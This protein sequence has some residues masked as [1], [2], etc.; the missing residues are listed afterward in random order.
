MKPLVF[1]LIPHTHWDREWYGT[2]AAFL[3]RLI[4]M[5]DGARATLLAT[6]GLPFLLDGQTV[7]LGDYLAARP[8]AGPD[9]AGL[10]AGGQLQTGP[11]R[12]LV[13]E[14]IPSAESL[15]RN[16]LQGQ[17]D[18]RA[19]GGTS[20]TLYS[21]DA[22]GHPSVLP[23]LAREFGLGG[24]ALWRGRLGPDDF[25]R[26]EAPDGS[27]L[28]VY[29]FPAAGY[30]VGQAL[31]SDTGQ[32]RKA[33]PSLRNELLARA[34]TRHV[35]VFIGADHHPLRTDLPSL[36]AAMAELE[37]ESEVRLSS[38]DQ[39]MAA[40]TAE[41]K[42]ADV[43]R[44]ELRRG[45][46]H[47]W[48]LQGVHATRLPL[49]RQGALTE[50]LL[51]R[52]AEPLA[53]L[54]GRAGHGD[55]RPL[56]DMAWRLV[57]ET[58][59][60]DTICGT[61]HDDA[62]AEAS[63]RLRDAAELGRSVREHAMKLL[64]GVP[65]V[66]L[67]VAPGSG[68]LL[69]WNPRATQAGGVAVVEVTSFREDVLVGPP[70]GRRARRVAARSPRITLDDGVELQAQV[71]GTWSR[72]ERVDSALR[73]PDADRVDVTRLALLV[74]PMPGLGFATA[75]GGSAVRRPGQARS[76]VRADGRVLRNQHLRV[77]L[78]D[79]GT[80]DLEARNGVT[81]RRVLE[82]EQQA[83]LGDCYT[84]SPRGAIRTVPG[85]AAWHVIADGPLLAAVEGHSA[86]DTLAYRLRLELRYNET[87]LRIR[88]DVDNHAGDQRLRLRV[89]V[90]AAP[91]ALAG[92]AFGHERRRS[93]EPSGTEREQSVATAPAQRFVAAASA[94]G[95]AALLTPGHMEYE[96]R[97]DGQLLFTLLR[98]T[99]ELSRA[100]LPERP[101]HAAWPTPVPGAQCLGWSSAHLA[102]LP[103]RPAAADDPVAV[104]A[105]WEA[106]FLGPHAR[107]YRGRSASAPAVGAELIGHGLVASAVKSAEQGP[108]LVLRAVNLLDQEV[109]G[110]WRLTPAPAEAWQLRADESRLGPLPVE[111]WAIP[112]RIG[113]R[114]TSTILVL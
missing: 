72:V 38:L 11:S 102:L 40:A 47:T 104:V 12:V 36:A 66:P 65:D 62:A 15:V 3:A 8:D 25:F 94:H 113:P 45:H 96:L 23:M 41:L 26:W 46:Q 93:A 56:L 100:D 67:S 103:C 60:H 13:D 32:L 4:P 70:D 42:D 58:Q 5:L 55:Q 88:L 83:D 17:R 91:Y 53:A 105:A 98:S 30:E 101:G 108:G 84:A 14:L 9:V 59:F 92:A 50:L 80:L 69:T 73:Y 89:P 35:A 79:D 31:P 109:S 85:P 57:T 110:A 86:T 2:R 1:H 99:G 28:P 29:H 37:S 39:F 27:T 19:L 107:W 34:V 24:I 74:P 68:S 114:A 6:P 112:L 77:L 75:L 20:R 52:H 22:F 90:G 87:F 21:P 64:G 78:R 95:G 43:V 44:G 71:L 10:V 33:W 111:S 63:Q 51:E 54:A 82:L 49:K 61:V 18:L 16:L 81:L 76:A 48:S 106:A 97:N 7:I